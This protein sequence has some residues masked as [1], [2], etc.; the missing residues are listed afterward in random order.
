MIKNSRVEVK[1]YPYRKSSQMMALNL[2]MCQ[3]S[4]IHDSVVL[5]Q[6]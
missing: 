1:G 3:V 4:S 5:G 2:S 6:D